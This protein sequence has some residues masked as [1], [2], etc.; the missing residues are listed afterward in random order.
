LRCEVF[1]PVKREVGRDFRLRNPQLETV[2]HPYSHRKSVK[3]NGK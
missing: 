3:E 1:L 2:T